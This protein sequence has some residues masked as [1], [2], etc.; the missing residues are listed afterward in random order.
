MELPVIDAA[1]LDAPD[2][3]ATLHAACIG[4]G[5]FYLGNHGMPDRIIAEALDQAHRFFALPL[6][7]RLA[8]SIKKSPCNRGYEPMKA[9]TLE[10]GDA[11]RPQ[12]RLL[13]R[14]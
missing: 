10:A 1:A 11:A 3:V 7:E 12:G 4:T 6:D 14:H 5:F 13:H 8:V 9:Q 2:T